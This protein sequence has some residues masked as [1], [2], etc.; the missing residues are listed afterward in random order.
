LYLWHWPMIV[1][2]LQYRAGEMSERDR[3]AILIGILCLAYLSW[4]FVEEPFR[5]KQ[6]MIT[7]RALVG[8]TVGL[9]VPL[10][11]FGIVVAL[12]GGMP[13]RLPDEAVKF[14]AYA[15]S[16]ARRPECFGKTASNAC[17]FGSNE[18]PEFAVW[19]DS[20]S[21]ALIDTLGVL[22]QAKGRSVK[23]FGSDGCPPVVGVT[24]GNSS[25]CIE[26]NDGAIRSLEKDP[27]IH[28]VILIARHSVYIRGFNVDFGPAEKHGTS[29][30]LIVGQAGKAIGL[31]ERLSLYANGLQHATTRLTKLGKRVI[32]VY[33]I[34][35]VGFHVP[36]TLARL[37]MYGA[38]PQKFTRPF[39]SYQERHKPIF[40][41][42]DSIDAPHGLLRVYPHAVLCNNLTCRVSANGD[43]LYFD[44]D[45]LSQEGARYISSIFA[46]I[47]D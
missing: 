36:N 29:E 35:E 26:R 19:G 39:L 17:T 43:A 5:R 27:N 20:H 28:T 10:V 18:K 42:L 21:Q 2:M 32:L 9:T 23:F 38:D 11:I 16:I 15:S 6:V 12:T 25:T 30:I 46:P 24:P 37:A 3:W 14:S 44:D 7:R 34:P 47:F 40:A 1:F 8:G 41:A 4:R 13:Q 31:N 45:H 22:A 33:P